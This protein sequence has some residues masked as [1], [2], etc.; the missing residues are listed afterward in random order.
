MPGVLVSE[1]RSHGHNVTKLSG[2]ETF[3]YDL[4]VRHFHIH[5]ETPTKGRGGC[6]RMRVSPTA[7]Y[8]MGAVADFFKKKLMCTTSTAPMPGKSN[9]ARTAATFSQRVLRRIL[10]FCWCC[11][12]RQKQQERR[13]IDPGEPCRTCCP[14][15][16]LLWHHHHNHHQPPGG[17]YCRATTPMRCWKPSRKS[18]GYRTS[19]SWSNAPEGICTAVELWG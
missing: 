19:T 10:T 4:P 13:G 6:S 15:C 7:R 12:F 14:A 8:E 5:V 3:G 17:G 9:P 18:T 1:S 16:S 11:L 2:L